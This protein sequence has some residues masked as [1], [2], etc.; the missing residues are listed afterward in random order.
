MMEEKKDVQMS[1]SMFAYLI[2]N[3]V[4]QQMR[5]NELETRLYSLQMRC[6]N[7]IVTDLF[8][9]KFGWEKVLGWIHKEYEPIITLY[10]IGDEMIENIL[11]ERLADLND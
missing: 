6:I 7:E 1:E 10:G 9:K 2:E 4:K 3:A 11:K 8:L 5:I